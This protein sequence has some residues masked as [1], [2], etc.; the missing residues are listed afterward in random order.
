MAAAALANLNDGQRADL[1]IGKSADLAPITQPE[2]AAMLNVSERLLRD[3]KAIERAAPELAR[4]V[5]AG[6]KTITQAGRAFRGGPSP[7]RARSV[8]SPPTQESLT[9]CRAGRGALGASGPLQV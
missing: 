8:P 2:A 7:S 3:A 6:S 1:K 4:E 9:P 5:K